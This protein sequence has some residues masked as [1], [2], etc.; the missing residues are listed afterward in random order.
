VARIQFAENDDPIDIRYDN[1]FKAVFTKDTPASRGALSNLVS[2]LIDRKVAVLDILANEPPVDDIRDRQVRFDINCK[3]E[4]GELI[5]VE[6]SYNPDPYEPERLEFYTGKLLVGQDIRGRFKTYN[7][8]NRV[9]QITILDKEKFFPD[10]AF[11][12]SFEYYDPANGTALNGRSRIITLEL[13]LELAKVDK[14][15]DKPIEGMDSRENWAVYFRY[16]TD[17]EKRQKINK[18]LEKEEGIAMASEVLIKISKDEKER[19]RLLSEYKYQVDMQSKLVHAERE[20]IKKGEQKGEQK[21]IE[22]GKQEII[23]LLKSGK[24]P[25]EII[26]EYGG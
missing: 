2:V 21:G 24:P 8:L 3:A 7:D 6:M 14:V 1:V 25:E 4:S 22:K 26:R 16:L 23:D 18:I 13:A 15:A 12:H 19:A 5:N 10:D 9:Y 17:R 20:G 11:L